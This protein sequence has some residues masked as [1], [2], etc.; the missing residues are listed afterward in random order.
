MVKIRLCGLRGP[1]WSAQCTYLLSLTAVTLLRCPIQHAPSRRASAS[2]RSVPMVCESAYAVFASALITFSSFS[3]SVC[4]VKTV[5]GKK[6]HF[7]SYR[8]ISDRTKVARPQPFAHPGANTAHVRKKL[9]GP[10][11]LFDNSLLWLPSRCAWRCRQMRRR[12]KTETTQAQSSVPVCVS[13]RTNRGGGPFPNKLAVSARWRWFSL[14][15][16]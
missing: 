13:S 2:Q 15:C 1:L 16:C 12:K 8:A 3:L 4:F 6:V 9:V 14:C 11:S 5:T 10:G 7:C